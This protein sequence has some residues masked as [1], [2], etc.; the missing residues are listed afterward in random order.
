MLSTLKTYLKSFDAFRQVPAKSLAIFRV[1]FGFVMLYEFYYKYDYIIG[2]LIQ[3][4]FLFTYDFFHWVEPMAKDN[5]RLFFLGS[6]IAACMVII[7]LAYRLSMTMVFMAWTYIFL[8]D[9]G[10]YNN[11]Y[12]LYSLI[13]L[14]M[15]FTGANRTFSVDAYLFP[16]LK[17]TI[18]FWNIGILRFQMFV[19]Y[20]YGGLAK[21]NIDWLRGTPLRQ[22]L[23]ANSADYP[24]WY[25]GFVRTEFAAYFYSYGGLV[26]DLTI[27]FLLLH[28]KLR[29]WAL[30]LLVFFHISNHFFWNIGSFPWFALLATS[31]F[32]DANWPT[33]LWNKIFK[34]TANSITESISIASNQRRNWKPVSTTLLGL[35]IAFQLLFPFRQFLY[36]GNP[37][38]TGEGQ[39]FAWR[40]MLVDTLDG[41]KFKIKD[42]ED[43]EY[44]EVAVEE[45]MLFN[46]FRKVTRTPRA[47]LQFTHHLR[48]VMLKGGA[49]D[50]VVKMEIYRSVNGRPY[51]LLADSTLNYAKVKNDPF[52][53]S[54]WI[55]PF[56]ESDSIDV[57][58]ELEKKLTNEL[59]SLE[60]N[61]R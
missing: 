34:K 7:G 17:G 38:W 14:L 60:L 49:K 13:S 54:K 51:A 50:P 12:Y 1:F 20:F 2:Y 59:T 44:Y 26:F 57:I 47:L 61:N 8:L 43:P 32:F 56:N 6:M 41:I 5:M 48:D 46:Q 11:H 58:W 37:S 55:M 27:G 9:K 23:W 28:K 19:V 4:E 25:Q 29:Y 10:H 33:Q 40:M 21:L 16:K 31:L 45:Y 42:A 53:S 18:P 52:S 39:F 22:W 35:F 36:Q 30:G 24:V 15:I 3:Q